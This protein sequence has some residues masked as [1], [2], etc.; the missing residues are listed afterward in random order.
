VRNTYWTV[1]T[2]VRCM[3][4]LAALRLQL[5]RVGGCE[6]ANRPLLCRVNS[7]AESFLCFCEN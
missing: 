1:L 3:P 6:A 5:N 7:P 4:T 2:S